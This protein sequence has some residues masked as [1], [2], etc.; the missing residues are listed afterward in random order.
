LT[1]SAIASTDRK[2]EALDWLEHAV[3]RGWTNYPLFAENDPL[4]KSLRED[5][6]FQMLMRRVQREWEAFE[7]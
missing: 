6:R 2:R 1:A 5:D 3:D 4:L 7:V